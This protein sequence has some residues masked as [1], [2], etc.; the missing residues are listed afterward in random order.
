[1]SNAISW[2]DK[3]AERV[4][5]QYESISPQK[6]HSWLVDLLPIPS[7][8]VLDVGSGSGRDAAWLAGLGYDVVAAEP[9]S[10]MRKIAAET[11]VI[12]S[13]QWIDDSMP[14][15]SNLSKLGVSFDVILLSAVWMHL[16]QSE[17]PRAFLNLINL[18]KPEGLLAI[19][20][21][22]GAPDLERSITSVSKAEIE[23]L[24]REQGAFIERC[25]SEKDKLGRGNVEWIQIAIRLS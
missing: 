20:L 9:S 4:S 23:T 7:A 22:I 21:R 1:M 18:L 14:S 17:R 25:T 8:A 16:P 6:V 3:N 24:A 12:K 2:Y 15:L 13:I 19:T 10:K 11:H 5:R